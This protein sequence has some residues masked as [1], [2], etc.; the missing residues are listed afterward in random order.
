MFTF[1][2]AILLQH[3][4]QVCVLLTNAKVGSSPFRRANFGGELVA[5]PQQ[6]PDR[7]LLPVL[8]NLGKHRKASVVNRRDTEETGAPLR[9]EKTTV[10]KNLERPRA[11]GGFFGERIEKVEVVADTGLAN[12]WDASEITQK[13]NDQCT[14]SSHRCHKCFNS[15][16]GEGPLV[17]RSAEQE[18]IVEVCSVLVRQAV[19]IAID[20]DVAR[21][22]NVER[23][24]RNNAR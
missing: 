9:A 23:A 11:L 8:V 19:E 2:R 4:R 5:G 24:P 3:E 7:N 17:L 1:Q 15:Y 21:R 14:I 12:L 22:R 13:P 20:A 18:V 6:R 16:L 10:A